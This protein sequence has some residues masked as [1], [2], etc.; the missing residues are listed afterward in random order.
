MILSEVNDVRLVELCAMID[1]AKIP[2]ALEEL[3][4]GLKATARIWW[5]GDGD[6]RA[7]GTIEVTG[8]KGKKLY[9]IRTE[10]LQFVEK[11]KVK[12][13]KSAPFMLKRL[14]DLC[15]PLTDLQRHEVEEAEL[16]EQLRL[17]DH[18]W[19]GVYG[20]ARGAVLRHWKEVRDACIS[21]GQPPGLY[22]ELLRMSTDRD[23]AG[24]KLRE[25]R[26]KKG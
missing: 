26:T 13:Y 2:I 21:T 3:E 9:A 1:E 12:R 10:R 4:A 11:C 14:T 23:E 22:Q 18:H 6:P 17:A 7:V 15:L 16:R 20:R 25:H 5:V 19:G 24:R 8:T